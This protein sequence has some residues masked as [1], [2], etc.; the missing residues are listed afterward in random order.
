MD[1]FIDS[2][3]H[4]T[5]REF[6]ADREEVIARAHAAGVRYL[7]NPGT[8]VDDSRRAVALAESHGGI[9]A[10]AG[11]HPHEARTGDEQALRAIEEIAAND[12]VVGI[13]EIGLDYHYD[14]APRDVQQRVFRD[15]LG[16]AARRNLPV[17]IHTREAEEDSL[18]I[19]E[20]F[21]AANPGWRGDPA[22]GTDRYP[23]LRGVFHCFPGDPEMAWRVINLGFA[24][25]LPGIVT[26][27]NPGNAGRVAARVSAE[28]LLLETDAP[29]L[30][31]VPH[32]GT[33]N[34]PSYLPLIAE[35]IAAAQHL[36]V[37]DIRRATSYGAHLLFGVGES[38]AP[39]IVYRLKNSLYINLTIRC[40]A[41]CVFCDRKGSAVIKGHNLKI[42]REPTPEE[43]I[44]Q[45]G[46]PRQVDEIVFC[47]YGEPTIRLEALKEVAGWVKS[48][49]G[50]TRL[51]TDGHG[52]V[53]AGRNIVPE[54]V[55]LLDAVSIS[56]NSTDPDQYGALMRIDGRKFFPAMVEFAKEAVKALPR[57]VMTI[58]DLNEVDKE[59]ARRLVE[60]EIGAEF[61]T[62]PFF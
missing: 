25:S 20:E 51:N 55:G 3:T 9:Y 52:S 57:V 6:D 56:L 8:T 15:Q 61:S 59:N 49:G 16:I 29:Y 40:N 10:C 2:H 33:R 38:P 22:A 12:R 26:F 62:R 13:G 42:T 30:T 1:Y 11:I 46:D 41:D 4:L 36:T 43:V 21:V 19:V 53:I 50:K 17:V 35:A 27:K 24:V 54:L 44:R 7:V 32:R 14:F 28:H 37:H 23:R 39:E 31:P 60:D 5:A 58:V 47:G 45:L 34:E 48:K 18:R